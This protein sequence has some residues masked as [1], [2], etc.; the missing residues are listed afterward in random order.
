VLLALA[1]TLAS[2]TAA[3][4]SAEP[5]W[6]AP[7]A[8]VNCPSADELRHSFVERFGAERVRAG[9][10]AAGQL[11]ARISRVSDHEIELRLD[12]QP[13]TVLVV[14]RL[15]I[16]DAE[17][18][19][20]ARTVALVVEARLANLPWADAIP[21]PVSGVRNVKAVP[22]EASPKPLRVDPE[23]APSIQSQTSQ[24]APPIAPPPADQ[25]EVSGAIPPPSPTTD[26]PITQADAV[27]PAPV[28]PAPA[29]EPPPRST[30]SEAKPTP[31]IA[32]P[33]A[34]AFRLSAY[35]LGGGELEATGSNSAWEGAAR[36]GF[37]VIPRLELLLDFALDS[38][39]SATAGRGT[40]SV[41][42]Q[43]LCLLARFK[44]LGIQ[45]F[46]L[47]IGLGG[48]AVRLAAQSGGYSVDGTATLYRPEFALS[49][50]AGFEVASRVDLL[51][52]AQAALRTSEEHLLVDGVQQGLTLGVFRL[53]FLAGIRVKIW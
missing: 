25:G 8:D 26:G 28:A 15:V 13:S 31:A 37:V 14:R 20:L 38:S 34:E 52:A 39:I 10:P 9:E 23:D 51:I 16:P 21:P 12:R 33:P 43:R 30:A 6:L 40:I 44:A 47:D 50:E 4:A 3:A 18:Q 42:A 11:A 53:H 45:F 46:R 22:H 35:L 27:Q 17:C 5:V 36:V 2:C 49:V 32:E 19:E 24:V 48:G 29:A 1:A 7:S 41:S